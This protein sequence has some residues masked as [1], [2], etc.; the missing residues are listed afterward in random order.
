MIG[1][2]KKSMTILLAL[3]LLS[4]QAVFAADQAVIDDTVVI[5]RQ[6]TAERKSVQNAG[7]V[8]EVGADYIVISVLVDGKT[9]QSIQL[10]VSDETVLIDSE[11]MAAVSLTD[12]QVGETVQVA[13]STVMTRSLPP[14][15]AA[16]MIAVHTDKG[17]SV[18]LVTADEVAADENGNLA[19]TDKD[20]DLIVTILK[21][22]QVCPYKTK[23]IVKLHDV[24][25]GSTL[26]LWYEAVTLSIPAKAS[27]DKVVLVA[28]GEDNNG[29]R[30]SGDPS[31]AANVFD[32]AE[33]AG[34]FEG[35][36]LATDAKSV[37]RAQF[38]E[39]AYNVLNLVKPFP[40]AAADKA[41]NDTDSERIMQLAKAEVVNGKAEGVFA[42][43][44]ALRYEEAAVIL[45]R[46]ADYAGLE[47][48]MVKI[49]SD[50]ESFAGIAEWALPAVASLRT[51][52][53][54]DDSRDCTAEFAVSALLGLYHSIQK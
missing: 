25:P 3:A 9:E 2:F 32:E 31:E 8:T 53:I 39:L 27:T 38:A 47:L 52:G 48:P 28:A 21:D 5:A 50:A 19:V 10:N 49:D 4:G 51:A 11:T 15:S 43:Q 54:L 40:E 17:G 20:Q 45:K 35:I 1:M 34:F 14:Q 33:Q 12:I 36:G 29:G 16:Y 42:P 18:S 24:T 26:L 13:Y 46:M 6:E 7:K 22:A 41:F 44:D 23:N 30:T 37:T